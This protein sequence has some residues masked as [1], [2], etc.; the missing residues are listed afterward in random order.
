MGKPHRT[1]SGLAVR[2][3]R[4]R[5]RTKEELMDD[6]R[7]TR[8]RLEAVRDRAIEGRAGSAEI[9]DVAEALLALLDKVAPEKKAAAKK[10]KAAKKTAGH[11]TVH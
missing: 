7:E 3:R 10:K 6:V 9:R 2:P 11:R 1:G 4:W 5:S 8:K